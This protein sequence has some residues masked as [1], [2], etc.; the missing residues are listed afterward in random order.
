MFLQSGGIFHGISRQ[1]GSSEVQVSTAQLIS[2]PTADSKFAGV[3][4]DVIVL[5]ETL[6]IAMT[7]LLR[8][9]L[10]LGEVH[11]VSVY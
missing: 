4:M 11:C 1:T 5:F 3:F 2:N 6:K 10:F 7:K 9:F 8:I